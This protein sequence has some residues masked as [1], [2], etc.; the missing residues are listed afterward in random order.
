MID[1]NRLTLPYVWRDTEHVPDK[2][3]TWGESQNR[4]RRTDGAKPFFYVRAYLRASSMSGD[5]GGAERL[6]GFLC[7][8]SLNPAIRRS[9]C[10]RAGRA[11]IQPHKEANMA[12]FNTSA[13]SGTIP[14]VFAPLPPFFYA[15]GTLGLTDLPEPDIHFVDAHGKEWMTHSVEVVLRLIDQFPEAGPGGQ[16]QLLAWV[17]KHYGFADIWELIDGYDYQ[18][19]EVPFD[20]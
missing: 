6:A 15:G 20:D 8:R 1:P 17:S 9:P 11:V 5:G 10:L 18:P 13:L 12:S 7:R 4:Q 14:T 2:K 16:Q 3:G 19:R